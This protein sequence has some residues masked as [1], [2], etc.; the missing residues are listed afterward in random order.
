MKTVMMMKK[1]QDVRDSTTWASLLY[2]S[3]VEFSMLRRRRHNNASV[4]AQRHP[5]PI[6]RRGHADTVRPYVRSYDTYL[7]GI[8]NCKQ[9]TN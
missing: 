2:L 1:L 3:R 9:S 6:F 4:T 8:N 7:G 5:A